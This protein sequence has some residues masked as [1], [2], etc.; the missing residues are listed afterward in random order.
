MTT[1]ATTTAAIVPTST[2][3]HRLLAGSPVEDQVERAAPALDAIGSSTRLNTP[4]RV[5]ESPS[6]PSSAGAPAAGSES[7]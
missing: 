5:A 4:M 2:G 7:E 6:G 3:F 1:A